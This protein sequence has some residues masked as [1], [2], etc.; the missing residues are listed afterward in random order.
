[1]YHEQVNED[2]MHTS[3]LM[4]P[5][6]ISTDAPDLKNTPIVLAS[7]PSTFHNLPHLATASKELV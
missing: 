3:K 1:M 4:K 6:I 7:V 2:E 5:C